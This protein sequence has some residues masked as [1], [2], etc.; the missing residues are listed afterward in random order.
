MSKRR[1]CQGDLCLGPMGGSNQ[2]T[3]NKWMCETGW[4]LQRQFLCVKLPVFFAIQVNN[5][6]SSAFRI[7]AQ[8]CVV[9]LASFLTN[10][11]THIFPYVFCHD[12]FVALR[13]QAA[14]CMDTQH[15]CCC[16]RSQS[17]V[18]MTKPVMK[19]I[20]HKCQCPLVCGGLHYSLPCFCCP[21]LSAELHHAN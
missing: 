15:G 5:S 12:I 10:E 1:S 3:C 13:K 18:P 8:S 7:R 19:P 6:Y 16:P 21:L 4:V 2:K 17:H 11:R 14:K 20:Q 9:P